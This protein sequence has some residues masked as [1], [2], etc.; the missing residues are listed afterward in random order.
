MNGFKDGFKP[1]EHSWSK[2]WA[3]FDEYVKAMAHPPLPSTLSLRLCLL[4]LGLGANRVVAESSAGCESA[5]IVDVGQTFNVTLDDRWYLLYFPENYEP[6]SPAPVILSYHGGNR[7]A[8]EQ[9][10]LD[11]LS[12]SYFNG[13][14]I[15]VYPNGV[16]VG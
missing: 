13:D 10:A 1:L 5:Q 9:Q 11:L 8:S 2:C 6:T 16:D 12:T 14:Y 7:N 3:I 15:V 4:G